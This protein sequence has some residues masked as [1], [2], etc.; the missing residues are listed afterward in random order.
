MR[1]FIVQ[2]KKGSTSIIEVEVELVTPVED[3]SV[4]WLPPGEYKARIMEPKSL[5]IKVDTMVDGKKETIM[6]PD[7]WFSHAFYDS[8]AAALQ[9][10]QTL[11]EQE[12]QFNL[13]KYGKVFTDVDLASAF[14]AIQLVRLPNSSALTPS[15]FIAK[16]KE[17]GHDSLGVCS[18]PELQAVLEELEAQEPK[19]TS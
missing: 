9:A 18:D 4:M 13:R 17:A 19:V 12:Y 7:M 2:S 10:A 15:E 16:A 1:K 5:Y 11:I 6:V 14:M 3:P 8:Y